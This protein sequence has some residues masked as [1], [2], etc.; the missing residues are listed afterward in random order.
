[1]GLSAFGTYQP[2]C[3]MLSTGFMKVSNRLFGSNPHLILSGA[4]P[5]LDVEWISEEVFASCGA[6]GKIQIM[7]LGNATPLRTLRSVA[8]FGLRS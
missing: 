6:D 4:E 2:R 8:I 7:R 5:C 1:M 3:Y